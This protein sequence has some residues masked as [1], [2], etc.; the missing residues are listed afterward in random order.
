MHN[1]TLKYDSYVLIITNRKMFNIMDR[2]T[3]VLKNFIQCVVGSDEDKQKKKEQYAESKNR[4][5]ELEKWPG[6]I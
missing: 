6:Q 4:L 1:H 3:W 2:C 5:S